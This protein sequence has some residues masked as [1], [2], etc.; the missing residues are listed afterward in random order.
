MG[1]RSSLKIYSHPQYAYINVENEPNVMY[2][3]EP[4]II[5][6]D[7]HGQFY[8]FLKILSLCPSLETEPKEYLLFLGDYVDRGPMG[9]EVIMLLM[10]LKVKYPKKILML[11]G[12]HETIQ[13]TQTMNFYQ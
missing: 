1:Q 8:D 12:N 5:I 9:V 3:N 13:M 10:A 2:V 4:A 7:I 6:G 11:R